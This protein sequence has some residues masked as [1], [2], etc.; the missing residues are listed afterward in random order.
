[1]KLAAL[2]CT[3]LRPEM[4]GE[5]IEC[6]CRQNYPAHLR[7][8]VI[9]DDSGQYTHEQGAGWSLISVPKR[10]NTLGEKRN[11]CAAL[12]SPDV[13]GFLIADDD[14]IYLSHWFQAHSHALSKASWSRPSRVLVDRGDSL[15]IAQTDGL[16]HA[17]WGIRREAFYSVDGY[18]A[19]NNGEDQEFGRRLE[20]AG[21][22]QYDPCLAT[23]PYFIWRYH[24]NT[25]HLS[26]MGRRGYDRLRSRELPERASIRVGWKKDYSKV[27]IVA[28]DAEFKAPAV[29]MM[30]VRLV[31]IQ[32][33][34]GNNGP[35]NG[36]FALQQVLSKSI[37]EGADW[38]SIGSL[39]ESNSIIP[40]F[41]NWKDRRQA[42]AWNAKGRPFVQG[43]NLLF[44]NSAKPRIDKLECSLLD[45]ANCQAMFCHSEWYRECIQS[46]KGPKNVSMIHLF[47]YPISP[48]PGQ[49]LPDSHDLLI[50]CK[51]GYSSS[52]VEKLQALFPRHRTI[53]YGKYRRDE[54]FDAARRS[55]ACAYLAS[56]DH[57]PLALQEIMLAGCPAVGVRT[58]AAF[59]KQ[60]RNGFWV[61][62]LPQIAPNQDDSMHEF[63]VAL[64]A[65]MHLD[66]RSVRELAAEEFAPSTIANSILC[67]LQTVRA[68]RNN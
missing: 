67:V 28:A 15:T 34:P 58:G 46:H 48:W 16:Y 55:R 49:P 27:P 14:D 56:D 6:F 17:A 1:M 22:S 39:E 53:Q 2:C 13:E 37:A 66:R 45:A 20:K 19:I 11:A 18:R 60:G 25:Y 29:D 65:A 47:P 30:R 42:V 51:N 3:F 24:N 50:Y 44:L 54:L 32:D 64:S 23:D 40:W 8:L 12:A 4:L 31:R 68:R 10:F 57:G 36:M 61:S 43:P 63:A 41:W 7:E 59:V 35:S 38:L 62:K 26:S 5:L 21:T 52:L 33:A 9:L